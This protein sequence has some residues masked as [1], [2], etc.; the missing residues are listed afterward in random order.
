MSG[1][2]SGFLLDFIDDPVILVDQTGLVQ[3][4]NRAAEIRTGFNQ[5]DIQGFPF[6]ILHSPTET[7]LAKSYFE[8]ILEGTRTGYMMKLVRND[9]NSE[10]TAFHTSVVKEDDKS[11]VIIRIGEP[12]DTPIITENKNFSSYDLLQQGATIVFILNY[13]KEMRVEYVSDNVSEYL[14]FSVQEFITGNLRFRDLI[15]QED[16]PRYDHET[17]KFIGNNTVRFHRKPYRVRTSDNKWIWVSD[18]SVMHHNKEG[19]A[20]QL[21]C[22]IHDITSAVTLSDELLRR[23]SEYEMIFYALPDLYFRFS[24][25]GVILDYRAGKLND[26]YQS[27]DLFLNKKFT[28]ILPP[29]V[30]EKLDEARLN[31]L[32][33]GTPV[34]A[35]YSLQMPTGIEYYEARLA[36]LMHDQLICIIRNTTE[37]V[38]A[39]QQYQDVVAFNN[40]MLENL[41]FGITIYEIDSGNCVFANAAAAT[42][43][44][45]PDGALLQQNFREIQSWKVSGFIEIVNRTIKTGEPGRAECRLYSTFGRMVWIDFQVQILNKNNT[46]HLLTF[47]ID[48]TQR[49]IL[50]EL[51]NA[52]L[53]V[54]EAIG[55]NPLEAS[56]EI[57]LNELSKLTSSHHC[58]YYQ[59]QEEQNTPT[60]RAHSDQLKLLLHNSKGKRQRECIIHDALINECIEKKAPFIL[61]QGHEQHVSNYFNDTGIEIT[62]ALI[63]PVLVN[64]NLQGILGVCNKII[65]YDVPDLQ[66]ISFFS[67][68][69]IEVI[70]RKHTLDALRKSEEQN[71]SIISA[72]AGGIILQDTAG[73][74]IMANNAARGILRLIPQ[75]TTGY[76]IYHETVSFIHEDG[77]NFEGSE[78]PGMMAMVQ[79]KPIRN[80]VMGIRIPDR[81]LT[82][83]SANAQPVFDDN[84][85]FPSSVIISFNDITARK[86]LENSLI[87][88]KERAEELN[89]IKTNFLAN[90]SHELRTPLNGILGFSE[91]LTELIDDAE[92]KRMAGTIRLSGQRLLST[93]NLILNLAKIEANKQEIHLR[94]I[95]IVEFTRDCVQLFNGMAQNKGLSLE[96]LATQE[97][98]MITLDPQMLDSIINNLVSN[99]IKYTE[100]GGVTV[101]ISQKEGQGLLWVVIEVKDSGIGIPPELQSIVFDPFRQ[102]SEG[103]D[104]TFE[105]TGLGLT[106]TKKYVELM[107]G[108]ISVQS[109]PGTGSIF[110]V[111]F[112]LMII[113]NAFNHKVESVTSSLALED[114]NIPVLLIDDDEVTYGI[115]R[116]MLQ[117]VTDLAYARSGEEALPLLKGTD[118]KVILLDVNLGKGKT[119]IDF[120]KEIRRLPQYT[121]VPIVAITAYAMQGDRKKLLSSGYTHYLSKPFFK[122]DILNLFR[123]ILH[124]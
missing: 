95:N 111:T 35:E 58:F 14:G 122:D 119:G 112:P 79:S 64:D 110:I 81:P 100:K 3:Q 97:E 26:L 8:Q 104:R 18:N 123:D 116:H 108:S 59:I 78:Y 105:G 2:L 113:E 98:I 52:R 13:E 60:L 27:P 29:D 82:W 91:I 24:R 114:V 84:S 93:L 90:M 5:E 53:K 115:A 72:V 42:M 55:E 61:G 9:N 68:L 28:D 118:Y 70:E 80:I 36:P 106:I 39:A 41:T 31:V 73:N 21:I 89:Q 107:N 30:S 51:Q 11:T 6:S 33:T 25:D 69:V 44:G 103:Y 102:V 65:N 109:N 37:E 120:I 4:I 101:T 38:L 23:N 19:Q 46:P 12:A 75:G 10:F 56:L 66:I 88:A 50:A 74:I 85:G 22:Y 62:N 83:I 1:S 16:L 48:I 7:Q 20:L 54:L 124:L 76:F 49:K 67:D 17:L 40:S 57:V 47:L 94:N 77:S 99:G 71:R 86:Q 96:F 87:A 63:F 117:K 121:S 45:A 43:L 15:R 34:T 92:Q 32:I